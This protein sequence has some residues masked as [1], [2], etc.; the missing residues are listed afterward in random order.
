MVKLRELDEEKARLGLAEAQRQVQTAEQDLVT[1]RDRARDDQRT[2]ARPPSGSSPRRPTS[3]LCA[4]PPRP[5]APSG[6]RPRSWSPPRRSYTT[7]YTRAEG[8]RRVA[9]TRR[10]ELIAEAIDRQAKQLDELGLL[11][12]FRQ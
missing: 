11:L 1:A 7:A 2:G 5:S 12:H 4:R 10:A 6:P 3:K 9:E 8:I